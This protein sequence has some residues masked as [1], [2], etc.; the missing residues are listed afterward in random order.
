QHGVMTEPNGFYYMKARY[1]D[2]NVGRFISEDPIGFEGGDV[3]LMVY[4][5]ANPVNEIDPSG[6]FPIIDSNKPGEKIPRGLRDNARAIKELENTLKGIKRF[7]K[8]TEWIEKKI[9]TGG[10]AKMAGLPTLFGILLHPDTV[11]E[12]E[13]AMLR[14]YYRNL[15]KSRG[16]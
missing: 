1:Y 2:P 7:N 9:L 8:F 14:D 5:G 10:V 4:V 11:N 3:N 15:D 12:N 16:K 6:L 13:D